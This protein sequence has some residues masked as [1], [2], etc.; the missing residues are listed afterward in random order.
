MK[1]KLLLIGLALL[2]SA[3]P[4]YAGGIMMMGGG[5]AASAST[6]SYATFASNSNTSTTDL[7][8]TKP[9]DTAEG[10]LLVVAV[11]DDTSVDL[12]ATGWTV[13]QEIESSSSRTTVAYKVAGASEGANYTFTSSSTYKSGVIVRFTKSGGTWDIEASSELAGDGNITS[14]A[15]TATDN[16]VLIIGFGSDDAADITADPADMTEVAVVLPGSAAVGMW[17]EARSAGSVQKS[18]SVTGQSNNNAI[19][20]VV[21]DVVS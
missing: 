2:A 14:T 4:S 20:A 1:L 9:T 16:S 11:I 19:I 15:V 5:V 21:I 10:D 18:I 17:Y 8:I 7:V 3:S 13:I 6:I 12:T